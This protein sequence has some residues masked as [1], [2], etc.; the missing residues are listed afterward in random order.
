MVAILNG[1]GWCKSKHNKSKYLSKSLMSIREYFLLSENE[2]GFSK[3]KSWKFKK[4]V[5]LKFLKFLTNFFLIVNFPGVFSPSLYP[6][7][8]E[9]KKKIK[10]GVEY[11]YVFFF[12]FCSIVFYAA[13]GWFFFPCGW[14]NKKNVGHINNLCVRVNFNF[15]F[16]CCCLVF[17]FL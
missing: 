5:K 15:V 9:K 13:G 6:T 1:P 3:V 12:V 2:S 17:E 10:L 7:E 14:K 16:L 8:K 11:Y 4:I